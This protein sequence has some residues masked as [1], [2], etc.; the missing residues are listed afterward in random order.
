MKIVNKDYVY[1]A[2]VLVSIGVLNHTL[3]GYTLTGICALA[4]MFAACNPEN[5][6]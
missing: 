4:C 1:A 6:K 5:E 2:V 3:V